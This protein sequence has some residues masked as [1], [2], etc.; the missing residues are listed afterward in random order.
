[1]RQF[2]RDGG[3]QTLVIMHARVAQ[4]SYGSEKRSATLTFN[5]ALYY[6][7]IET[8]NSDPQSLQNRQDGHVLQIVKFSGGDGTEGREGRWRRGK[9]EERVGGEGV[10]NGRNGREGNDRGMRYGGEKEGR[11]WERREE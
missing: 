1:M 8:V 5:L 7:T 3:E 10:K 2:L 4:K 6:L 11:K 9:E